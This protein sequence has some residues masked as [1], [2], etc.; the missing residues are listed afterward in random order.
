M[1]LE[2][3]GRFVE[4]TIS[5]F[6]F[7]DA[8]PSGGDGMGDPDWLLVRGH[9]R[10]QGREWRFEDACLTLPEALELERWLAATADGAAAGSDSANGGTLDFIEPVLRFER[11]GVDVAGSTITVVFAHEAAPPWA[12][13]D[14]R[15]GDGHPVSFRVTRPQLRSLA[16]RWAAEQAALPQ[17]TSRPSGR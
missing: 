6:Q 10:D 13:D 7:P 8:A 4:L 11:E 2:G 14:I 16:T 9:V 15:F 1:R 17:R 12:S 5:G 3:E